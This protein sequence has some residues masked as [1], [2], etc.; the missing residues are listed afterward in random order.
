MHFK[1]SIVHTFQT[2]KTVM[3]LLR[4]EDLKKKHV[5]VVCCFTKACAEG[6]YGNACSHVCGHCVDHEGCHHIN[7]SCLRG[8]T[9]GYIGYKCDRRTLHIKVERFDTN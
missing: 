8:C 5:H 2:I 6:F 9:P 1:L 7:G 4:V 3:S